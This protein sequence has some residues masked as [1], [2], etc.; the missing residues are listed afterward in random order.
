MAQTRLSDDTTA[1]RV[2]AATPARHSV[3]AA[4]PGWR[5]RQI[6]QGWQLYVMLALPLLYLAI[7][8][9]GP[10]YGVQI[11]FRDY[12][13]V[14]GI[15]GSPWV[16]L[17]QFVRFIHSYQ[18]V[19][20]IKNTVVLHVYEL[21]A[22]APLPIVLALA[23]NYVRTRWF[24]RVVQMVTYAPH[25]ISTV[26]IVGMMLL[27]FDPRVGVFNQALAFLHLPTVD[28][29]G[30]ETWFRHMF[31]AS[32]VWQNLGFDA[33]I[34]LAALAGVDPELHEAAIVDGASKLKRMWHIDLPSITPVFVILM[35]LNVGSIMSIGFEK[36]LLMQSPLNLD[37]SQV[38]NTYVYQVGL[39]SPVPQYSYAAAIGL[40]Q[41][42]IGLIMLVL[43][44]WA[45][46]R[47]SRTSL[48]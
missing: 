20:I 16:G 5:R 41:G 33:I 36:A 29:L 15:S 46:R 17:Q 23:L 7:Y 48:W 24:A 12:N 32:S 37:I 14:D 6:R 4:R 34:Y 11:A 42:V 31:V 35:I 10:I 44:N 40:F 39:K 43:A 19:P 21:A 25:F 18:F 2:P 28:I 22:M 27:L 47:F 38:I 8:K 9:Y 30:G 26:V 3:P 45:A 13:P 1:A